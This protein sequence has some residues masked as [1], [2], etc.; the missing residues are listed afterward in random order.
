M[1]LCTSS[2]SESQLGSRSWERYTEYHLQYDL[3]APYP[4]NSSDESIRDSDDSCEELTLSLAEAEAEAE[5]EAKAEA[6]ATRARDE[7]YSNKIDEG[8]Y[9]DDA[10]KI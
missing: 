5:A 8:D 10:L 6:E 2:E 3:N 9:I 7:I 1:V 4:Y